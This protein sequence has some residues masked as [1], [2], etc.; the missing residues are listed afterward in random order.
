MTDFVGGGKCST[1]EL[2]NPDESGDYSLVLSSP[3]MAAALMLAD[4]MDS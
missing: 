4:V 3:S 2:W 1:T